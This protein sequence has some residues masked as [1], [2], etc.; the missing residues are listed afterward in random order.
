M[1]RHDFNTPSDAEL[2]PRPA[3]RA[4]HRASGAALCL[5]LALALCVPTAALAANQEPAPT[6]APADASTAA[7]VTVH[8]DDPWVRLL[9]GAL[10]AAGYFTLYNDGSQPIQLVGASSPDWKHVAMHHSMEHMGESTMMPV[11]SLNVPAHGSVRFA[12]GSYHLML[13]DAVHPL[14][15]GGHAVITLHFA[16][17]ATQD[18][19][20][21]LKPAST[22]GS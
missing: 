4:V 2:F 11:S 22:T 5:G 3:P 19:S 1:P 6:S 21:S 18:V 17:G 16:N 8:V 10:P 13:H 7:A 15:V 12:P 20:F 9:P 14:K